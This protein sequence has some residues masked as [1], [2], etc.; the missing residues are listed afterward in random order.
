MEWNI[1]NSPKGVVAW[2]GPKVQRSKPE[3]S[4][5]REG[6][7]QRAE[8]HHVN[9]QFGSRYRRGEFRR[10]FHE[11]SKCCTFPT[12]WIST[13][14][15]SSDR[16]GHERGLSYEHHSKYPL[17]KV[18]IVHDRFHINKM[19]NEAV[20]KLRKSEHRELKENGDHRLTGTT[21]LWLTRNG[22]F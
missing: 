19:A 14:E 15:C 6:F 10:R 21:F 1:V 13:S 17:T 4:H 9:R 3:D 11:S 18:R 7:V 22:D 2:K 8:L 16:D 20:D 12:A 5:W